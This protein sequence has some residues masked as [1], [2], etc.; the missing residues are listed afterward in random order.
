[1]QEHS[2]QS[3]SKR[4]IEQ[5]GKMHYYFLRG[6]PRESVEKQTSAGKHTSVEKHTGREDSH[7]RVSFGKRKA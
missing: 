3:E 1:M 7:E 2:T 5:E 4:S 6:I